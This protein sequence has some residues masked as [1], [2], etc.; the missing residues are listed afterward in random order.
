MVLL[1]GYYIDTLN[2]VEIQNVLKEMQERIYRRALDKYQHLLEHEIEMLVDYSALN[3]IQRPEGSILENAEKSL[4]NRVR[5]AS[6][7][8]LPTPYNFN[9]SVHLFYDDGKTFI[10]LNAN[11]NIYR[12]VLKGIEGLIPCNVDDNEVKDKGHGEIWKHLMKT[13][14]SGLPVAGVQLLTGEN[15]ELDYK[16]LKFKKPAARAAYLARHNLV[17][18]MLNMFGNNEQIPGF[19]LM[20]LFDD[21]LESLSSDFAKS[22]LKGLQSKLV[23]ALPNITYALIVR[24]K[25]DPI[26]DT[27]KKEEEKA[28]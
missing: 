27:T 19:R 2:A 25:D 11:N 28:E 5:Y 3:A 23:S 20:E 26:D 18:R 13:Y 16:K 7:N 1:N 12:D 15:F 4:M 10:R 9:V 8:Q 17:N 21:A 22:E 14:E 6:I 24:K